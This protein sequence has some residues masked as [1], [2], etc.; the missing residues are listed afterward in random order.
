VSAIIP[1]DFAG[2]NTLGLFF[3]YSIIY[4]IEYISSQGTP[5]LRCTPSLLIAIYNKEIPSLS[6]PRREGFGEP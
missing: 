5:P 3:I 1:F 4:I 2:F 6:P